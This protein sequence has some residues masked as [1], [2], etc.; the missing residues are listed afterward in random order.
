M[1]QSPIVK[2]LPN[3]DRFFAFGFSGQLPENAMSGM[4]QLAHA[5]SGNRQENT[6]ERHRTK[7]T[8]RCTGA[9]RGRHCG[10]FQMLRCAKHN[11]Y[12]SNKPETRFWSL[13]LFLFKQKSR[14]KAASQQK[15]LLGLSVQLF[16]QTIIGIEPA[17]NGARVV[18]IFWINYQCIHLFFFKH[19]ISSTVSWISP[20]APGLTSASNSMTRGERR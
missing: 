4:T 7:P 20:P 10:L 15:H 12:R 6:A 16:V 13:L 3:L 11:P 19:R 9:T 5:P 2:K 18:A 14:P 17:F 1:Q 8:E